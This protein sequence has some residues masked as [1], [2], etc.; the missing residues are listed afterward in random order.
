MGS[1]TILGDT[2]RTVVMPDGKEWLA[3]NFRHADTPGFEVNNDVGNRAA[4]GRLY[5]Y[6]DIMATALPDGWRVAT[7]EDWRGLTAAVGA[8]HDPFI[9]IHLKS[10]G[11]EYWDSDTGYDT[12]G[13]SARG[14]G[15]CNTTPVYA[16]FRAVTYFGVS[17]PIAGERQTQVLSNPAEARSVARQ[18]QKDGR[19][20]NRGIR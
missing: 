13:F 7:R 12:Y 3:E 18:L 8:A 5:R 6:S 11:T 17:D 15:Y 1:V 19:T 2:Y 10:G 9:W 14:A 4:Y 20:R 16:A